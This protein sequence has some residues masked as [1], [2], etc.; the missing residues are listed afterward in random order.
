MEHKYLINKFALIHGIK[1][2][3]KKADHSNPPNRRVL[4]GFLHSRDT[5]FVRIAG[6]LQSALNE[7]GLSPVFNLTNSQCTGVGESKGVQHTAQ[8]E[9][10]YAVKIWIILLLL[11][12][13]IPFFF[14]CMDQ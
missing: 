10:G 4:L 9:S 2:F 7:R 13:E 11:S 8:C 5:N 14:W 3:S 6:N 12:R 1:E